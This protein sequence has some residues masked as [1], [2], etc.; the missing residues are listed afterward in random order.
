MLVEEWSL[1]VKVEKAKFKIKK[2]LSTVVSLL[3]L[4][5]KRTH[6]RKKQL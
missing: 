5:Q 1:L 6:Q 4:W 2:E 3:V